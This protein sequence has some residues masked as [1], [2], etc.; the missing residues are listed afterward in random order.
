MFSSRQGI[1]RHLSV[2]KKNSP[3][4]I[5]NK[6]SKSINNRFSIQDLE[7]LMYS[8]D[9]KT[10][11]SILHKYSGALPDDYHY[12]LHL[13][14]REGKFKVIEFLLDQN[15]DI[16]HRETIQIGLVKKEY[17][18]PSL[19][20]AATLASELTQVKYFLEKGASPNLPCGYLANYSFQKL[21]V[22]LHLSVENG[23]FQITQLLLSCG[24]D[25]LIKDIYDETPLDYAEKKQDP[26][27]YDLLS[28]SLP[29]RSCS[30]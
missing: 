10:I 28:K 3:F 17:F 2:F 11:A 26:A 27:L 7:R 25:P 15:L 18:G 24:A 13:A 6:N 30:P 20:Y 29:E 21:K 22:P 8:A 5:S 23:D 12:L 14:M 9:Y 1:L 16:N 4:L 19:L